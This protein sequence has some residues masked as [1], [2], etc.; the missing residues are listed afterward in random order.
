MP[1][2]GMIVDI[3]ALVEATI[4]ENRAEVIS[5][6]RE[7]VSSGAP[8][9]ELAGR[10]ALIVAHGDSDGHAILTLDA[11]A[12]MRRWMRSVVRPPEVGARGQVQE[13]ARLA[14]GPVVLAPGL[15]GGE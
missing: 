6:A 2:I 10:V 3:S 4:A 14:Q 13:S 15:R 7:L 8:A 5:I 9:A 11:V 1:T 12:A